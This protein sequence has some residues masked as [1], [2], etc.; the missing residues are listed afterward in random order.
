MYVFIYV[1]N[2]LHE[3]IKVTCYGI[4]WIYVLQAVPFIPNPSHLPSLIKL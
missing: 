3:S 2:P 1:P 4:T